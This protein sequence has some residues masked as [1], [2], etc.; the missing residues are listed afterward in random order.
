V[1]LRILQKFSSEITVEDFYSFTSKP[2]SLVVFEGFKQLNYEGTG[3]ISHYS[4]LGEDVI[5]LFR[6]YNVRL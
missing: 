5:F 4:F 6:F 3:G 2:N 1:K